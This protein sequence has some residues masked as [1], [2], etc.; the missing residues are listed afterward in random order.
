M[1]KL[2]S[3]QILRAIAAWLVVAHHYHQF[4]H[5]MDQSTMLGRVSGSVGGYAVYVFFVI[6]GFIMH[7]SLM[8]RPQSAKLFLLRRIE[9]IVPAYWL[10]TVVFIAVVACVG[11]GELRWGIWTPRSLLLSLGFIQHLHPAG[12]GEYPVLPIG[13]SL[14]YEMF[15]YVLLG[16]MLGI[17]RGRWFAPAL[18]LLVVLPWLA[19]GGWG[20]D[21]VSSP[22]LLLFAAGMLCSKW[23]QPSSQVL[24]RP[25]TLACALATVVFTGFYLATNPWPLIWRYSEEFKM[26]L[27]CAAVAS[28]LG[29]EAFLSRFSLANLLARLGDFS[30]STYLVHPVVLVVMVMAPWGR[31]GQELEW[32]RVMLYLV[33]VHLCSLFSFHY[34]ESIR[35]VGRLGN[36]RRLNV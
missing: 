27:A 12:L 7:R 13:W 35:F 14:N 30:Y 33:L 2:V 1:K 4:F 22:L 19:R 15:F 26:F 34:F 21:I 6:S 5:N 32:L 24:P 36:W 11:T 20:Y 3:L 9:R 17:F 8:E 28:L 25:F 29:C 18:V 16:L 31:A 10:V 23:I